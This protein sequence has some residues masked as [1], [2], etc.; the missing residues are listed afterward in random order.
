MKRENLIK[1]SVI[2]SSFIATLSLYFGIGEIL[3]IL[4]PIGYYLCF[5]S[6]VSLYPITFLKNEK[7][8][9]YLILTILVFFLTLGTILVSSFIFIPGDF[10]GGFVLLLASSL[11]FVGMKETYRGLFSGLSFYIV[12]AFI[13]LADSLVG[14][15]ILLADILDYYINCI[16][17]SCVS[18]NLMMRPEIFLFFLAIPALYPFFVR[19]SFR[20]KGE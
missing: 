10:M 8:L 4:F 7:N 5:V 6:L 19:W 9:I 1:I 20:R 18:Y 16:G 15:F 2:Y 14:I 3:K 11:L 17:E 13:L 12:G